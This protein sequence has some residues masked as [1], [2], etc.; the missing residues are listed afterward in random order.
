M[1]KDSSSYVSDWA[2]SSA[3]KV[4]LSSENNKKW[5]IRVL[6]ASVNASLGCIEPSVLISKINFS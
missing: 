2:I 4:I 5:W 6:A 1:C 3:S